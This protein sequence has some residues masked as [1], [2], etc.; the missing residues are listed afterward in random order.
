M[1]E[2]ETIV[3]QI[4]YRFPVALLLE[5]AVESITAVDVPPT[6]QIQQKDVRA[7]YEYFKNFLG[8]ADGDR[9]QVLGMRGS[10]SG[11]PL[12]QIIRAEV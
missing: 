7:S 4:H 1:D 6:G 8:V 2:I 3:G 9:V 10:L 12:V 5:D 11:R